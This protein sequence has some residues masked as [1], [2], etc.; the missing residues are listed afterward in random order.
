MSMEDKSYEVSPLKILRYVL[1][2]MVPLFWGVSVLPFYMGWV[3]AS[4][5]LFPHYIADAFSSVET[6]QA[7]YEQFIDFLLGII[8]MGP[9]L[10]G[11]TLV[12]NDYWDSE[13]DKNSKR[14]ALFPLP[15]GL[16]SHKSILKAAIVLMALAL[17]FA[18]FV[19]LLF[20]FLVSLAILL[21]ICYST[22][23]LR[24][25]NR[26][27]VDVVTNA[28][29]SGVICSIAGWIVMSPLLDYPVLWGFTSL[30]GVSSIYIPTTIIDQESDKLAGVNTFAV[31]MGKKNAFYAGLLC[32]TIANALI[33]IMGLMGYLI[34]VGFLIV[35]WPVAI[36]QPIVYGLILRKLTFKSVYRTI[37]S[38]AGLLAVGNILLL[39]YYTGLW[40]I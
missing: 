12:Y 13:V 36:A 5:E 26:A 17:I 40:S 9:F 35:A 14:K 31:K 7:G 34:D 20:L 33:I 29:G 22:P 37:M 30:F 6:T 21:S 25:K 1:K 27:G 32:V 28:I 39:T 11:S 24:L 8:V 23:P 16:I 10:G 15:Q 38:L 3:F 18:F 4:G 19:S 2:H